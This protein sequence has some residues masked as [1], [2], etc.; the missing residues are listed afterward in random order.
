M[1]FA[2]NAVEVRIGAAHF[3]P[4]T[5]RPEQGADTGLLPQ[6][7]E[8]LNKAQGRFHFVLVPT[9]IPRR[10]RDFEQGRV[11]MAIFENPDWGWQGIKHVSVDM[12]LEDAEIFVTHRTAGRDQRYFDDLK[13]KR[14]ALFSGYHYA[15]A[16]FNPDPRYL[17]STYDATL[18]YSHDSN[19]LMVQRD[20]ADIA[21][22]T[23]SY[24]SDYLVRNPESVGQLLSSERIDQVYH[25]YALLRPQARISGEEFAALLD[26]LRANGEL[27]RIFQ[28]YQIQVIGPH[29]H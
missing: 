2:A 13:G 12:G 6:L 5:V 9:S 4:Y 28:P 8:A 18:T 29:D 10:F 25:H 19:L 7:V 24:L 11:D 26:K 3:P 22:V 20:R 27:L 17:A 23:R 1:A 15:F 14:L 16:G 21:L